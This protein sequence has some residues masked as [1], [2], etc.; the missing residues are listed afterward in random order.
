MKEN[1]MKQLNFLKKENDNLRQL[2]KKISQAYENLKVENEKLHSDVIYFKNFINESAKISLRFEQG[3]IEDNN[4][5][6]KN[7]EQLKREE[8]AKVIKNVREF[9]EF[10]LRYIFNNRCSR[11]GC[12]LI[13]DG[14][15]I[16]SIETY[17]RENY[18]EKGEFCL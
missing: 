11:S 18:I 3:L 2:N 16:S 17:F 9:K 15:F 14:V 13:V 12:Y 7:L 6:T 4:R 10:I 1:I 5:L 8:V